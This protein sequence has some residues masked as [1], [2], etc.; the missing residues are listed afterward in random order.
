[1][2]NNVNLFDLLKYDQNSYKIDQSK[3]KFD[4]QKIFS[5]YQEYTENNM[6][7]N[8]EYTT[9]F[10]YFS[11]LEFS[12]KTLKCLEKNAMIYLA[13]AVSDFYVP[14]NEMPKHKIQSGNG[15]LNLDLKPVPKLVGKLKT[16]W[17]PNAFLITFKLETDP[18]LLLS[19]CKNSLEKYKHQVVIGNILEKRKHNVIIMQSNGCL[20]E[21]NLEE[22]QKEIEEHIINCLVSLHSIFKSSS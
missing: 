17:C 16:D 5:E 9:L 14:K 20:H 11:L 1:M 8:I 19:K 7:L 22:Q 4:F 15:G 21:I 18:E 2:F 3:L 12:C 6:L 10:D 13:A